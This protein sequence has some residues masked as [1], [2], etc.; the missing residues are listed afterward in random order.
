MLDNVITKLKINGF[1]QQASNDYDALIIREKRLEL[2]L[3]D[4]REVLR[5]Q[6]QE[7]ADDKRELVCHAINFFLHHNNALL[8]GE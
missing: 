7:F 6:Q 3:E 1:V 5:Q 2:Q 8:G 4:L